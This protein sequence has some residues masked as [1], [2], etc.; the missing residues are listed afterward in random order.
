[1][2]DQIEPLSVTLTDLRPSQWLQEIKSVGETYGFFEPLGKAHN[3]VFVEKGDTL[4]V[5][6]ETLP[7]IQALTENARPVAFDLA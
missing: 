3:A 5:S 2:Q 4:L 6:F 7:A 1:M